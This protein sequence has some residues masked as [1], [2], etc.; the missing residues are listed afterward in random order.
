MKLK[1]SFHRG[2]LQVN[3]QAFGQLRY[4]FC[5][6]EDTQSDNGIP[7]LSAGID[8]VVTL[9][10]FHEQDA[11]TSSHSPSAVGL[12]GLV[13]PCQVIRLHTKAQRVE[14]IG[15]WEI[16]LLK[17]GRHLGIGVPTL[18]FE[19][20]NEYRIGLVIANRDTAAWKTR[21]EFSVPSATEQNLPA[22]IPKIGQMNLKAEPV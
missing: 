13:V 10:K 16:C 6:P 21:G 7:H 17:V 1:L 9:G 19:T 22:R 2:R 18:N 14:A 15:A 12:L 5:Q 4:C 8:P 3:V 11:G 20:S